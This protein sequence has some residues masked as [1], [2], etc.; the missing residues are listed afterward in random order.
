MTLA[1]WLLLLVGALA[2]P[3]SANSANSGESA[4]GGYQPNYQVEL[5]KVL[6]KPLNAMGIYLDFKKAAL[7]FSIGTEGIPKTTG[8]NQEVD[9]LKN[10]G[11][12]Q[13]EN[14]GLPANG[15][16]PSEGVPINNNT[17]RTILEKRG[18]T[19]VQSGQVVDSFD[20]QITATQGKKGDQLDITESAS[21]EASGAYVTRGSAG[22]TPADR[23]SNLALPESNTAKVEGKVKLNRDQVLLEGDVAPQA[24]NPGFPS[25][26]SGGG[27]QVFTDAHTGGVSRVKSAQS[28]DEASKAASGADGVS[29]GIK[30][31]V[32][33]RQHLLDSAT[34]PKLKS[35]IDKLYRPNAVV[36]NGSTADVIRHELSTGELLS[37]K[38]HFQKGIEMRDGLLKDIKSGRLNEADTAITRLLLKDLQNALSGQ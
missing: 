11:A 23:Q 19:P 30:V 4:L 6:S 28:V 8:V 36:G 24:G 2:G 13:R 15:G 18:A 20:G 3:N 1:A 16:I 33:P 34:D 29:G 25:T 26:A 17:A 21:G 12:K 7:G 5:G 31:L 35:R 32:S 9:S 38:G 22:S 14:A 10:I 27:K 37:P